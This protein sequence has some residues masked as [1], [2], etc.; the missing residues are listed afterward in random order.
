LKIKNSIV[1]NHQHKFTKNESFWF[2]AFVSVAVPVG[3]PGIFQRCGAVF[4]I[5][6]CNSCH[7]S[8]RASAFA[9]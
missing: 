3:N 7:Y 9:F 2:I 8:R 4:A 5:G 6:L 1:E